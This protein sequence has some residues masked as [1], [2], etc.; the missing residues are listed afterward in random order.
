MT[1]V[2]VFFISLLLFSGVA[3][4]SNGNA[5]EKL[6]WNFSA[7]DVSDRTLT[8][9]TFK[10][11]VTVVSFA[12]NA[13]RQASEEMGQF[14]GERF[15]SKFGFQ[16]VALINTSSY[17]FFLKPFIDSSIRGAHEDAVEDAL[18]KQ[19]KAGNENATEEKVARRIYFVNDSDGEYWKKFGLN[20]V[21]DAFYFGVIN[22]AGELVYIVRNPENYE[23]V[24]TAVQA[25]FDKLQS[26]LSSTK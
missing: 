3:N 24:A 5:T 6:F 1:V 19:K 21:S 25:Q 16:T 20:P 17:P 14:I 22:S 9:D 26:E 18:A 8:K 10:S 23:E 13:S 11:H 2:H 7:E 12:S 15:G 4:A